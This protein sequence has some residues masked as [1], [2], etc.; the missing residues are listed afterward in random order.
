[1]KLEQRDSDALSLHLGLG[2]R[3]VEVSVIAMYHCGSVE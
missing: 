3:L 1:M 2:G